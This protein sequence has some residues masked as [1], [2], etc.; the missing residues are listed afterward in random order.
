[1]IKT[2]NTFI[3]LALFIIFTSHAAF[4]IL[5]VSIITIIELHTDAT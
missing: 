5:S 2:V 4:T 3:V 1:M